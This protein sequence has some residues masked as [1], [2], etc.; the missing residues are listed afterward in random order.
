MREKKRKFSANLIRALKKTIWGAAL[1]SFC[2]MLWALFSGA[3]GDEMVYLADASDQYFTAPEDYATYQEEY[4]AAHAAEHE[5]TRRILEAIER[6]ETERTLE[7]QKYH[8]ESLKAQREADEELS[9]DSLELLACLVEAEAGNQ[10]MAGKRLVAD[11]VLNRVES[12]SFPD[13]I[14][15]VVA[16]EGQFQVWENG[17]INKVSPSTET[18]EA[19]RMEL[20]GPRLNDEVIFFRTN[21]FSSF[22][23][24]WEKIG[25][26]YFCTISVAEEKE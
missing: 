5:E 4:E 11:V 25:D 23:E 17:R 19:V 18:Y 10:G 9:Y 16:Q 12:G 7:D 14:D 1:F 26:H 6:S 15:E 2:W 21:R 24:P 3:Q 20:A 22:G 8:E 13:S